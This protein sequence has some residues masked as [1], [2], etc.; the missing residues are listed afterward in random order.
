M[1][2]RPI[3]LLSLQVLIFL[4]LPHVAVAQQLQLS[5]HDCIARANEHNPQV[6]AAMSEVES[7]RLMQSTAYEMDLT[8]LSLSQDPTAG[9]SPDNSITLSQSFDFPTVYAAR[10][11]YLRSQ[12]A[13][14]RTSAQLEQ[15][16]VERDVASAYYNLVYRNKQYSILQSQDSVY[17]RFLSIAT[18]RKNAGATSQLELMNAQ[19]QLDDSRLRLQQARADCSEAMSQLQLLVATDTAIEPIDANLEPISCATDMQA[20]NFEQTTVAAN[21]EAQTEMSQ[22]NLKLA[23]QMFLPRINIGLR[24]QL[25]LKA[26]NPYDIQRDAFEKGN[27]MGFEVGVSV[28]LFWG[29]TR[30]KVRAARQDLETQQLYAQSAR[31]QHSRDY[32][33]AT[34]RLQQARLALDYYQQQGTT[35]AQEMARL[36]QAAYEAG[37]INYVEYIQNQSAAI[38]LMLNHAEA[39][40]N[41]N[42]ALI[43]LKYLQ[44]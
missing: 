12:T 40:N 11:R 33:A 1:H 19:R 10:S 37:E 2:K 44:K 36:S 26:F 39:V 5:L 17:V 4:I 25:V 23:R 18:A 14:Q 7:K 34:T 30:A 32:Q 29:S 6:R 41:Y 3:N 8:Q 24:S 22:R 16:R 31:L 28:P 20:H 42:Q 35:Q 15:L 38:S 9:G 21:T 13:A 27:F 43:Q